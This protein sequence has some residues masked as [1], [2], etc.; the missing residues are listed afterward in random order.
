MNLKKIRLSKE[1]TQTEVAQAVNLT[2]F[3]Y[4]NYENGKTEPNIETLINLANYY[5]VTIDELVGHE[6]PYL[7][8][9]IDF[10]SEQLAL[11]DK[12]KSL[13]GNQCNQISAYID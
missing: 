3:T 6:V 13:N 7:I 10:T 4:S 2:Q 8:N 11:I 9:K 1:K 5:K 12:I